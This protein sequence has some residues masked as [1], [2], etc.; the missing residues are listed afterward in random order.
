MVSESVERTYELCSPGSCP[1]AKI[2]GLG[3]I[4][5]PLD[6]RCNGSGRQ[7]CSVRQLAENGESRKI[8]A[9]VHAFED[10]KFEQ[11][12]KAGS[13][14]GAEQTLGYLRKTGILRLIGMA[15]KP[16]VSYDLLL[17]DARKRS[18]SYGMVTDW[19][20]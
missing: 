7:D 4:A 20:E 6:G 1:L 16:G 17:A 9:L 15:F 3:G 19:Q 18:E 8:E 11:S 14:V 2:C 13:D 10:V 5:V 12:R